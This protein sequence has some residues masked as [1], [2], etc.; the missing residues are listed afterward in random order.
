[1]S[2]RALHLTRTQVNRWFLVQISV[3]VLASLS[4]LL[5][6]GR[7]T[8]QSVLIGGMLAFFPQWVFAFIWLSYYKASVAPKL[9]RLFYL[10]EVFKLGTVGF[11]FLWIY[12]NF[13]IHVV[14]CLIGLMVGQIGFWIAPLLSPH[15][16]IKTSSL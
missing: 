5:V 8:G 9:V 12:Q 2:F 15:R 14:A 11:S 10:G 6:W 7:L 13:K 4:A 1:M 16:L 3:I